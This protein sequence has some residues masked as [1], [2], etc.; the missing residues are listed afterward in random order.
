VG[1]TRPE[2]ADGAGFDRSLDQGEKENPLVSAVMN[3][4]RDQQYVFAHRFVVADEGVMSDALSPTEEAFVG[5]VQDTLRLSGQQGDENTAL[6]LQVRSDMQRVDAELPGITEMH[7]EASPDTLRA[8]TARAMGL[9]GSLFQDNLIRQTDGI[10]QILRST[11]M[12]GS[13]VL[14]SQILGGLHGIAAFG[15]DSINGTVRAIGNVTLGLG[16]FLRSVSIM[17]IRRSSRR[18]L[19][20]GRC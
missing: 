13:Q 6:R 5:A 15:F 8:A 10:D 16:D 11:Q 14:S 3:R 19:R 18:T 17:T 1:A 12:S 2:V 4:N 7:P 20:M 9:G